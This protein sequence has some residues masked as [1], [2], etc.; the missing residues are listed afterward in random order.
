MVTN[1]DNVSV[2]G[3][4]RIVEVLVEPLQK[5]VLRHSGKTYTAEE[6]QRNT[7]GTPF[8]IS[9]CEKSTFNYPKM[10]ICQKP[11]YF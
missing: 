9:G 2:V 1:N 4:A 5:Q 10:R 3:Q 7:K 8:N 6:Y 11:V